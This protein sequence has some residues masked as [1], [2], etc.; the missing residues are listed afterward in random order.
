MMIAVMADLKVFFQILFV[1]VLAALVAPDKDILSAH[2]A[3]RF[4][5]RL[6][7][8]FFLT[9]PGHKNRESEIRDQMSVQFSGKK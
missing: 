6:D 7:L 5:H 3:F 2:D 4:A 8:A 9:K 1:E